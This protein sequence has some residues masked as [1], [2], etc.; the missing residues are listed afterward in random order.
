MEHPP[1]TLG[2]SCFF[3]ALGLIPTNRPTKRVILDRDQ[4]NSLLKAR[5]RGG[6]VGTGRPSTKRDSIRCQIQ[7]SAARNFH[8]VLL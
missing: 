3:C 1:Y 6:I 2:R 8:S 4:H 7:K 5:F